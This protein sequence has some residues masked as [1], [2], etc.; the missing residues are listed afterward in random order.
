MCQVASTIYTACLYADLKVTERAPH[1]FTVTY[2]QLG[3][4]ATI[5]WGSLD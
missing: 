1:M 4:D 3:M 5:Y 2:V